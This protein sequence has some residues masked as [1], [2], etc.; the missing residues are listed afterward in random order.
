MFVTTEEQLARG[1]F[2]TWPSSRRPNYSPQPVLLTYYEASLISIFWL[3]LLVYYKLTEHVTRSLLIT[4][5]IALHCTSILC[6]FY[7]NTH[8]TSLLASTGSFSQVVVA[9]FTDPGSVASRLS[10]ALWTWLEKL[11]VLTEQS[12]LLHYYLGQKPSFL[13]IF[14]FCSSPDIQ[15]IPTNTE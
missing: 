6:L 14:L 4:Q 12:L 8:W 13:F 15:Q 10:F 2:N 7:I 11:P 1:F 3:F 5:K 9:P